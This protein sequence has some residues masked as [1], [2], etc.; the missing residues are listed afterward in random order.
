MRP[1]PLAGWRPAPAGAA[2]QADLATA[3][4]STCRCCP[5][6]GAVPVSSRKTL[7][8]STVTGASSLTY[9]SRCGEHPGDPGRLVHAG[10]QQ[11]VG[12]RR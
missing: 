10:D 9:S 4:S 3:D 5:G 1:T 2:G 7:S 6:T 11:V 12:L 8:R